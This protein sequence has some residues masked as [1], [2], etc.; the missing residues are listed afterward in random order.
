MM[1]T[2]NSITRSI[3]VLSTMEMHSVAVLLLP[4]LRS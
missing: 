4:T 2:T 3:T 1:I